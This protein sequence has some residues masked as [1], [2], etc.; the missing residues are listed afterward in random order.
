MRFDEVIAPVSREKFLSDHWNQTFLHIPGSAP[1]FREL[2]TWGEL[3]K[4]L[5]QQRLSPPLFK[6]AQGGREIDAEKYLSRGWGNVSRVDSGKLTAC[7]A[8]G[9]TLILDCVEELSDRVRDLSESFCDT[10]RARNY[11]NLYAGWHQDNG[12]DLHWDSQDITILQL[13]GRKRW[14]V[15]APTRPF[16][17]QGDTETAKRPSGP[18]AWDGMLGEGDVLYLPRGW[19]HVAFPVGEPSLHLTVGTVLPTGLDFL[20]ATVLSLRDQ[21]EIRRDIPILAGADR[22]KIYLSQIKNLLLDSLGEDSL[23]R[24]AAAWHAETRARQ[25][26]N[27]PGTPYEQL[28]E[29]AGDSLLRLASS[30]RLAFRKQ[31]GKAEFMAHGVLYGIPEQLVPALARL[32]DRA[33]LSWAELSAGLA[34]REEA[35]LKTA[36]MA[37]ARKGVVLVEKK[38]STG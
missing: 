20:T 4:L 23:T 37:L 38:V 34:D 36:V 8:A 9:A 26:M 24:F 14:Q 15:F 10:F 17:L 35:Q 27:L 7:L 21:L 2:F 25:H 29:L 31:A 28:A 13:S 32:S 33:A 5:E 11:V 12:S 18:P 30:H 1:R 19:W 3:N 6:L 16:P 22:Q